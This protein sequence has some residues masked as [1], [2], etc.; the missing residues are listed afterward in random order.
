MRGVFLNL[1]AEVRELRK[2]VRRRPF[3]EFALRRRHGQEKLSERRLVLN[4][5]MGI[6]WNAHVESSVWNVYVYE[7]GIQKYVEPLSLSICYVSD[8]YWSCAAMCNGVCERCSLKNPIHRRRNEKSERGHS[9]ESERDT[10]AVRRR[11]RGRK[12]RRRKRNKRG[13]GKKGR[14]GRAKRSHLD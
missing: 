10:Q 14:W 6:G 5:V 2:R 12:G 4:F 1:L 8:V 11:K 3:A 9:I 7:R 13:R